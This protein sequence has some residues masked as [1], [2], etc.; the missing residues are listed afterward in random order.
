VEA[1]LRSMPP[2]LSE[3]DAAPELFKRLAAL[4]KAME[5][6]IHAYGADDMNIYN[7]IDEDYKSLQQ[8][9]IDARPAVKLLEQDKNRFQSDLETDAG[10]FIGAWGPSDQVI[11]LEKAADLLNT[12]DRSCL[13]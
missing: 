1:Q 9:V 4:S 2:A 5:R 10:Y 3:S 12:A 11:T 8:A 6:A 7:R 13:V